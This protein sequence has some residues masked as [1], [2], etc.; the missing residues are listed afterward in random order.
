M[1]QQSKKMM[2]GL[3]GYILNERG[4][5]RGSVKGDKF[6]ISLIMGAHNFLDESLVMSLGLKVSELVD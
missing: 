2:V 3:M 5:P 6:Q 1:N 4:V